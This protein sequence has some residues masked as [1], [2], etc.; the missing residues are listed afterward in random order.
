ML[1]RIEGRG[2]QLLSQRGVGET[3]DVLGPLGHAF[4][5]SGSKLLLV[6]GGVGVPP[7]VFLAEWNQKNNSDVSRETSEAVASVEA[8]IG[9]RG[10]DD[11]VEEAA[12]RAVTDAL[13]V[14]T[15]DGSVGER[16]L[17]TQPLERR[18]QELAAEESRSGGVMVCACGPWPMLRAV[19]QLCATYQVPCQVSM[20][21]NMPCG[22]GVCNG[23][24]VPVL[25]VTDDYGR[26]R[27]IC[28]DGPVMDGAQ[29]D[30]DAAAVT[31]GLA[32]GRAAREGA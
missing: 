2:T 30:W 23:C 26:Y 7:L 19:A 12:L 3:L 31:A 16:G 29:I 18:L 32:D 17:V 24:V 1:Y 20:E 22:I 6:G 25:G 13:F 11:V 14:A 4:T 5:P 28:V 9:A 8:F 10:A 27:R 21:E 15:Q